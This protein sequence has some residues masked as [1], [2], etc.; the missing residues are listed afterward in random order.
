[1][2]K[3]TRIEVRKKENQKIRVAAYARVSTSQ[4][5][6][7]ISL[8][9]QKQH[10]EN[11]IKSHPGWEYVGI[12]YDEGISGTKTEK[13]EGLLQ[14]LTDCRQGKI[15]FIVVKSISRFSRNTV[16]S[17][18]IVRE[19]CGLGIPMYFEKENINTGEMESEF[20]LS[21]LSSFA[22]SE[23]HSISENMK[24]GIRQRFR[25]GTY[26]QSC[27]PY[28]YENKDGKMVI[29]EK[30]AV[31]VRRIFQDILSGMS[32]SAIARELNKEGIKAP[33]GDKWVDGG[34]RSIVQN[35]RYIG[36]VL[37][38]KHFMDDHF[39]RH[40]NHGELDQYYI[41]GHHEAILDEETFNKANEVMNGMRWKRV[42]R[43]APIN[44]QEGMHCPGK[45]SAVNAVVS[46]N[47][48]ESEVI[49]ANPAK[50]T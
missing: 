35:E 4:E 40:V 8:E 20:F 22:E 36:D 17:I 34:I 41:K 47:A 38:Q 3:K 1:M 19:L 33:R 45:S 16:D 48:S 28:G 6:Q 42:S 14:M 50:H 10:Y 18:Q 32:M 25:D 5:E 2:K 7:L 11:Y 27:M 15:D 49:T 24:W 23:S 46:S 12:Y 44:T 37:G 26:V 9:A 29:N 31:I 43:W 30:Q 39:N 21:V 13:R